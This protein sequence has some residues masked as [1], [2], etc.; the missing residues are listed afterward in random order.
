MWNVEC[1]RW[2]IVL[3]CTGEQDGAQREVRSTCCCRCKDGCCLPPQHPC[4]LWDPV[5]TKEP[6]EQEP[7]VGL[8]AN[9]TK[10][11]EEQEPSMELVANTL[12]PFKE[13][14]GFLPHRQGKQDAGHIP[15][16]IDKALHSST[17]TL[18]SSN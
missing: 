17:N 12:Q 15:A 11:P 16:H 10:E 13:R 5:S 3:L 14:S 1:P 6:E 9:T 7:G 2:G 18:L 8:V 4:V